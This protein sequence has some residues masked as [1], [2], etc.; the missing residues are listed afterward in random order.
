MSASLFIEL[1]KQLANL[2]ANAEVRSLM[3]SVKQD[4]QNETIDYHET[5][6]SVKEQIE[7]SSFETRIMI[8]GFLNSVMYALLDEGGGESE[9]KL[10]WVF[11]NH[12]RL[13]KLLTVSMIWEAMNLASFPGVIALKWDDI[14]QCLIKIQTFIMKA[15]RDYFDDI[16]AQHKKQFIW[17]SNAIPEYINL[18]TEDRPEEEK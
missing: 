3:R 2:Q 16:R 17:L 9:I 8:I 11:E 4:A 13:S 5:K 14:P 12:T 7:K 10:T 15:R 6:G 1:S 18:Y